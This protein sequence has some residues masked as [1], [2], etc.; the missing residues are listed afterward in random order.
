MKSWQDK[1]VV[2]LIWLIAIWVAWDFLECIDPPLPRDLAAHPLRFN[3]PSFNGH[4]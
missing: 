1:L 3:P 4:P 2:A